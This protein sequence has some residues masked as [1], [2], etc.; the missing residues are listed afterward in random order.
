ML[1][2]RVDLV[3]VDF[4]GGAGATP[5]V[6]P[7]T[8]GRAEPS[9]CDRSMLWRVARFWRVAREVAGGAG[10]RAGGRA[11]GGRGGQGCVGNSAYPG[12]PGPAAPAGEGDYGRA[13]YGCG[14]GC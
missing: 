8:R 11:G 1:A 3:P 13:G 12:G 9:G 6:P 5:T 14:D 4:P 7:S 10:G 2:R